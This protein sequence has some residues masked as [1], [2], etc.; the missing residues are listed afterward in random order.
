MNQ[1]QH[2]KKKYFKQE[3]FQLLK[4]FEIDFKEENA[5]EFYN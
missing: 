2:H 4:R 5:F 1:K 3:Y